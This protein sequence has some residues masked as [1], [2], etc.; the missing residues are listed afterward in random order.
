MG[1]LGEL[2]RQRQES[3]G[4]SLTDLQDRT[5]IREKYIKAI[6]QGKY[7]VIPGEVYLRGFI[8]S[9][10]S[11]LGID[12]GEAMQAY[13]QDQG[14][15]AGASEEA[16]AAP[17]RMTPVKEPEPIR[18]PE[19]PRAEEPPRRS[20]QP[21]PPTPAQRSAVAAPPRK[22]RKQR[23]FT[24]V[25]VVIGLVLLLAAGAWYWNTYLRT[26]VDDPAG[27]PPV[28]DQNPPPVNDPE[29]PESTVTVNLTN[30]G[31]KDLVYTVK[32][33]PLTVNLS[34][35]ERGAC[36]LR[37]VTDEGTPAATTQ[38]LTIGTRPTEDVRSLQVEANQQV[39]IRAGYPT[40]L[41]LEI[42]GQNLGVVGGENPRTITIKVDPAP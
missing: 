21:A 23:S 8:R 25:A 22:R 28:V 26:P 4:L 11:E 15:T 40:A 20:K 13:Y 16:P 10:A 27:D 6:L 33:G 3:L 1:H 14:Q 19:V 29:P 36:W 37:V 7:D 9:I 18:S 31:E 41:I 24:P 34:T 38:E 30:P 39:F 17:A 42:N 2:L 35:I 32:P 5:K 12:P